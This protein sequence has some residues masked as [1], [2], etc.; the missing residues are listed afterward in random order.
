MAQEHERD[1]KRRR[2]WV[3]FSSV[4]IEYLIFSFPRSGNEA[5]RNNEFRHSTRNASTIRR[6]VKNGS[7]LILG[8]QVPSA[9]CAM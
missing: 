4:E 6:K 3:Q 9:Y 8:S 7:V 5:K 2:L 1:C